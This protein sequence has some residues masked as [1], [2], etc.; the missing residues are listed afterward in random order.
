MIRYHGRSTVANF[1]D[2]ELN[3]LNA[4]E[5]GKQVDSIY[6]DFFKPFERVDFDLLLSKLHSIGFAD[7]GI[8]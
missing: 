8:K 7:R 3:I 1:V 4:L 2:H 6:K 5:N